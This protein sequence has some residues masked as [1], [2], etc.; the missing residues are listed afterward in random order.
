MSEKPEE[1]LVCVIGYQRMVDFKPFLR[2]HIRP[3]PSTF[4]GC[5]ININ[6]FFAEI[7]IANIT[8]QNFNNFIEILL[9]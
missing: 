3:Q 5:R 8:F 6:E 2:T 9:N 4:T 7:V 1:N